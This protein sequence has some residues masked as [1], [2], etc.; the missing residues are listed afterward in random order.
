VG[1]EPS[2]NPQG[3]RLLTLTA[4]CGRTE[5]VLALGFGGPKDFRSART[6]EFCENGCWV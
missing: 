2:V 6:G 3:V 4:V 1:S 5:T